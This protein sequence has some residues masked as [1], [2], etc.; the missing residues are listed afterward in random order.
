M[1]DPFPGFIGL[2]R[3]RLHGGAADAFGPSHGAA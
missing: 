2:Y 3:W 1:N